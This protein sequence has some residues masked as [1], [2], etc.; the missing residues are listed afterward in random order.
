MCRV[1]VAGPE[2]RLKSAPFLLRNHTIHRTPPGPARPAPPLL[3]DDSRTSSLPRSRRFVPV[4]GI[5]G[6]SRCT[7]T[8]SNP[9]RARNVDALFSSSSFPGA[10]TSPNV[11]QPP[12]QAHSLHRRAGSRR[13]RAGPR[14]ERAGGSEGRSA[15]GWSSAGSPRS[16]ESPVTSLP[17]GS[18]S[19]LLRGWQ[20]SVS[21]RSACYR[22]RI[23]QP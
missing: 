11:I 19:F 8:P 22:S 4:E 21:D 3:P 10:L 9:R 23:R 16:R 12:R 5:R 2:L 7:R 14:A 1:H 13:G 6:Q 20:G 15:A 18:E 17:R